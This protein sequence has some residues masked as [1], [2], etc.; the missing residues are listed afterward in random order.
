MHR[1]SL[2]APG[3]AGL[4]G[5]SKRFRCASPG[6]GAAIA[7]RRRRRDCETPSR[8]A[9]GG[10]VKDPRE[11]LA[12]AGSKLVL[13]PER[14]LNFF[15]GHERQRPT[16]VPAA[17]RGDC[18]RHSA[19][20]G[21]QPSA[22]IAVIHSGPLRARLPE[23]DLYHDGITATACTGASRGNFFASDPQ[24]PARRTSCYP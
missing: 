13:R 2:P 11:I 21:G 14:G 8:L 9:R 10:A 7:R 16:R 3:N 15:F 5:A 24:G 12:E 23:I 19:V 20:A 17:D 1:D 22:A 4:D 6:S 18:G